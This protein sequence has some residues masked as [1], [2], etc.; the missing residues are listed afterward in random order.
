[1][2]IWTGSPLDLPLLPVCVSAGI[3]GKNIGL[4]AISGLNFNGFMYKHTHV[5]HMMPSLINSM[6]SRTPILSPRS[7]KL[8]KIYQRYK[9]LLIFK[10]ILKIVNFANW[11]GKRWKLFQEAEDDFLTTLST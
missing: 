6:T 10:N 7:S 9:L 4:Q 11:S 8:D 1:M 5:G 2:V 3:N